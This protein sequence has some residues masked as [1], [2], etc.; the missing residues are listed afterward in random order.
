MCLFFSPLSR[1]DHFISSS[2]SS[3]P[4]LFDGAVI[5]TVT[6]ATK[7]HFS[8]LLGLLGALLV[9]EHLYFETR[10][11]L[12]LLLCLP[13][14]TCSYCSSLELLDVDWTFLTQMSFLTGFKCIVPIIIGTIWCL[15]FAIL[16]GCCWPGL[17]KLLYWWK[18]QTP[19]A[20][21]SHCLLSTSF[22]GVSLPMVSHL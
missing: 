10:F 21:S 15:C 13:I 2:L 20:P 22:A 6:T 8:T 18:S 16:G 19:I 11:F 3:S 4:S 1:H 7:K 9:K 14:I 17:R 12:I 5:S